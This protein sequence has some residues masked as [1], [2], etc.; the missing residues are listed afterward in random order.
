MI[1]T[2]HPEENKSSFSFEMQL[3]L[4]EGYG[5]EDFPEV[6]PQRYNK[7][8]SIDNDEPHFNPKELA[9]QKQQSAIKLN[10][11]ATGSDSAS[12]DNTKERM[13]ME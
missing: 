13:P 10:P 9:I 7:D 4:K 3:D 2:D 6:E 5:F 8:K 1:G 11:F 12:K